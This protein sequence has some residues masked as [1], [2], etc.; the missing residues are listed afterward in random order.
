VIRFRQIKSFISSA[1][2]AKMAAPPPVN[3]QLLGQ[4]NDKQNIVPVCHDW[5]L[6][7]AA[8]PGEKLISWDNEVN[9]AV[10]IAGVVTS[11][12]F[13]ITV[14][15]ILMSSLNVFQIGLVPGII[16]AL[17]CTI[18]LLIGGRPFRYRVRSPKERARLRAV[19]GWQKLHRREI[20]SLRAR[21]SAF[22]QAVAA[23]N[24][25]EERCTDAVDEPI[26]IAAHEALE[27]Q[28][29]IL[30]A[31]VEDRLLELKRVE[32]SSSLLLSDGKAEAKAARRAAKEARHR[33]LKDERRTLEAARCTFRERVKVWQR[34]DRGLA[35]GADNG[36]YDK[37]QDIT[38]YVAAMQMR[39]KLEAEC[40]ELGLSPG[41]VPEPTSA[42]RLPARAGG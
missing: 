2:E 17:L 12:G 9:L 27:K 13:L 37:T 21:I 42:L 41:E 18:F 34:L 33:A 26:R 1:K 8:W 31:E 14:I 23:F 4:D 3:L 25:I 30:Q 15:G 39:A 10:D 29:K 5:A 11:A 6:E 36:R 28:R 19:R 20:K 24:E 35:A 16:S 40:L 38:P 7:Q 22:N 32:E